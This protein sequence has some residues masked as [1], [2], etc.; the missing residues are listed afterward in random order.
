LFSPRTT[1]RDFTRHRAEIEGL[2]TMRAAPAG[3]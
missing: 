3:V 1:P 2:F